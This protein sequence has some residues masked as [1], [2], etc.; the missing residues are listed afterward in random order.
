MSDGAQPSA[1]RVIKWRRGG[2]AIVAIYAAV[3]GLIFLLQLFP[4][5][6]IFLMF[7]LAI[8]WIGVVI[9][10]AMI[11][12]TVAALAGSIARSWLLVPIGFYGGGLAVHYWAV[13]AV[14]AQTQAIERANAAVTITASPPLSFFTNAGILI[15]LLELYRIDRMVQLRGKNADSPATIY[16]YARG[17]EYERANP[18]YDYQKRDQPFLLR[19]DL[20]PDYK[21][22]D[23]TRQCILQKDGPPGEVPYRLEFEPQSAETYLIKR[24]GTKWTVYDVKTGAALL[25]VQSAEFSVIEPIPLLLAGC[26]LVDS[27]P[28]WQ[29]AVQMMKESTYTGAGY[30]PD[31]E[32]SVFRS[33][34]PQSWDIGP[35]GRALSLQPR[36]PTD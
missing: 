31:S 11:H 17:E 15:D 12:L 8:M 26:G 30:R 19:R 27:P 33:R 6:G 13:A 24:F 29:C 4:G 1:N 20:F 18:N 36:L 28:S 32:R 25:S 14:A 7:M 21:G 35:L 2:L 16:Y 23:K 5:T 3:C 34:D 10:I 22:A 9:N